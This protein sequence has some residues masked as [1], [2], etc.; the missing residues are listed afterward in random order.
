MQQTQGVGSA[1]PGFREG[2]ENHSLRTNNVFYIAN[3]VW[4]W[5]GKLQWPYGPGGMCSYVDTAYM[6]TLS[7]GGALSLSLDTTGCP[8]GGKMAETLYFS[9]VDRRCRAVPKSSSLSLCSSSWYKPRGT[10]ARP[11]SNPNRQPAIAPVAPLSPG[12]ANTSVFWGVGGSPGW[13][14]AKPAP[15]YL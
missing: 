4:N 11:C 12:T 5:R 7:W 3:R 13:V 15:P 9:S 8:P 1:V 14:G 6:C 2:E 10:P